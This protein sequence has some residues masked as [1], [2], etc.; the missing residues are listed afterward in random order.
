MG[1]LAEMDELA[2]V[3]DRRIGG[4]SGSVCV[5]PAVSFARV[6]HA[7]A[8]L[9]VA[10]LPGIAVL[11]QGAKVLHAGGRSYASRCSTYLVSMA[12][13][14]AELEVL[15]GAGSSPLLGMVVDL[16]LPRLGRVMVDMVEPR[17]EEPLANEA[18][19]SGTVDRA[20]GRAL[21]RLA[22][23]VCSDCAWG[24]L[25]EGAIREVYYWTLRSEAGPLLR[26]R[27]AR[28]G[29]VERV[30]QA[31]RF[32]E[33]NLSEPLE[34][35]AIAKAAAL[36]PSSLHAR[37]KQVLG[38]PPMQVVKRLRLEA[39]RA[40]IA[41]GEGVTTAAFGVGYASPSQFSR[42]F[43]R[44]FGMAPSRVRQPS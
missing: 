35:A 30:S 4:R 18:L 17:S 12:P 24:A 32:I 40:Q 23:L 6:G 7:P 10:R 37:F 5:R 26:H 41:A 2:E 22:H 14:A 8:R 19:V 34:V 28:A 1:A 9:P 39:A 25:H 43:R 13:V 20:M 31:M 36:S 21:L 42:D 33:A 11:A 15:E 3:I 27:I 29:G 16:D 44:Q 38:E